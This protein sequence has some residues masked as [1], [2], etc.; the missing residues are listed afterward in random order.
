[1]VITFV[2]HFETEWNKQ[3]KLQGNADISIAEVEA[4]FLQSCQAQLPKQ[5][6]DEVYVSPL[7]RTQQTATELG[8]Q[9]FKISGLLSEIDF[10]E[11]EGQLKTRLLNV[12]NQS[13]IKSPFH[14]VLQ[15]PLMELSGRVN[16]FI[17][18]LENSQQENILVVGHGAWLRLCYATYVL[19]NQNKMNAIKSPNGWVWS[20]EI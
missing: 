20:M 19:Q 10:K 9:H 5:A 12:D 17:D 7:V 3:G 13:W 6:F 4:E 15:E 16:Q 14:S 1:M 11:Y 8:Y 2:R 18:E